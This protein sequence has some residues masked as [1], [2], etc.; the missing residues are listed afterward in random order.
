[1]TNDPCLITEKT[2]ANGRRAEVIPLTFGRA[3]I[4]LVEVGNELCYQ[5]VW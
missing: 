1:M 2:F 3:R 4:C 5:A